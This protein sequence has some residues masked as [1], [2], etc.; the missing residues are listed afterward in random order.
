MRLK[1]CAACGSKDDLH[2][3][4]LVI[5]S[6]GGGGG[7]DGDPAGL[8]TLC[9]GCHYRLH[10]RQLPDTGN[11]DTMIQLN[12]GIK[13]DGTKFYAVDVG[14]YVSEDFLSWSFCSEED[15]QNFKRS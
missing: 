14:Q 2:H 5:R 8:V 12:R 1:F 10:Q 7:E 4:D 3:H 13:H 15:A 6:E 11:A 9:N